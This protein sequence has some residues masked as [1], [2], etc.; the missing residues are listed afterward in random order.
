MN[1]FENGESNLVPGPAPNSTAIIA[2]A[3]FLVGEFAK[4]A[5]L[6]FGAYKGSLAQPYQYF[7][8]ALD[9]WRFWNGARSDSAILNNYKRILTVDRETFY[10]DPS[11]PTIR[12]TEEN[13]LVKAVLM[14]SWS[15]DQE[16]PQAG[17]TGCKLKSINSIYPKDQ[18]ARVPYPP[19][20]SM[21]EAFSYNAVTGDTDYQGRMFYSLSDGMEIDSK[22]KLTIHTRLIGEHQ[23]VVLMS[24]PGNVA[25][26]PVDFIIKV[27][28]ADCIQDPDD[29]TKSDCGLCKNAVMLKL[30]D[31]TCEYDKTLGVTNQFMPH[32]SI[33]ASVLNAYSSDVVEG[34]AY[35]V[36]GN[37]VDNI[38]ANLFP[39]SIRMYA[40]FAVKMEL[41]GLDMQ[42]AV[43]TID[44]YEGVY[45]DHIFT[46]VGFTLG[47]MPESA[48]F[49]TVHDTNP[50]QLDMSW[51][52]C[53]HDVGVHT[54][55]FEAVDSHQVPGDKPGRGFAPRSSS[56]QKCVQINVEQ[57]TAPH[58]ILGADATPDIPVM[59][60]MGR[61]TQLKVLVG[62]GNCQASITVAAQ[63][64]R[65][66]PAGA[67][68]S[69][70]SSGLVVGDASDVCRQAEFSLSWT[71][72]Q[73]QGGFNEQV[74]LEANS[75]HTGVC[76]G[77]APTPSIHC[78]QLYVERCKYAL[79][80]DQQLQEI[81]ELY[82]IDWMRLWSLNGA[83]LHPDYVIYGGPRAPPLM[84]GHLYSALSNEVP[85]EIAKRMGMSQELMQTLNYGLDLSSYLSHGDQLCVV[86]NSCTGAAK[87]QYS[88]L[89]LSSLASYLG[90]T[91]AD[92]HPIKATDWNTTHIR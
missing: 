33:K 57:E 51:T 37:E 4:G 56:M 72:S 50:S 71:P 2:N 76:A 41:H 54:L 3:N 10:G 8:G 1:L 46:K 89:E 90:Q 23:A 13:Y 16:C 69:L 12:I 66:L 49:T 7:D 31:Y 25:P 19:G 20:K 43:Q 40:G 9:E 22:G 82:S 60:T 34:N 52:P 78:M 59:C 75:L 81:A 55:C 44:G 32:L 42:E 15:F 86:P 35:Y 79:Q 68:L 88:A 62:S 64:G 18:D 45:Y 92:V 47:R 30:P 58:F 11:D 5:A 70:I 29:V 24:Y 83:L 28:P 36:G 61:K 84:V 80:E 73:G 91:A 21:Y 14:A 17:T 74:C 26:V 87:A 63:S 27:V 39:H 48:K 38:H 67:S 65:V 85:L 53:S 77:T 6:I